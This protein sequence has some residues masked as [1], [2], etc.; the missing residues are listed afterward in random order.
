MKKKLRSVRPKKVF[1]HGISVRLRAETAAVINAMGRYERRKFT[2]K[3]REW[4]EATAPEW[5]ETNKSK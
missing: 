2:G 5:R 4:I 3:I 1:T